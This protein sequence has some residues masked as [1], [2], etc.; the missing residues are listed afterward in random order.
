MIKTVKHYM[1]RTDHGYGDEVIF[2]LYPFRFSEDEDYRLF[3]KE[4]DVE[5]DV[6]DDFDPRPQ[7]IAALEAQKKKA[8]ADYQ[9]LMDTLDGKIASLRCIE[10]KDET[11]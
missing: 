7:Q 9:L 5:L 1:Y 8:M 10:H 6:P 3:I 11:K 2:A 4:V